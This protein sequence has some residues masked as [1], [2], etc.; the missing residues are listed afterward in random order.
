MHLQ[1]EYDENGKIVGIAGASAVEFADGSLGRMGR[2]P[3]PGHGL[4]EHETD[5][6]RDERDIEG[7]QRVMRSYRV[8]GHPHSPRLVAAAGSTR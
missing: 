1:L 8:T 4:I 7:M 6:V 3:K 5:D 2:T